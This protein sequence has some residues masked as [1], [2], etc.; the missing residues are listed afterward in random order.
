VGRFVHPALEAALCLTQ[1][2][3]GARGEEV[4]WIRQALDKLEGKRRASSAS[5]LYD[6]GLRR[7]VMDFQRERSLIHDGFVGT[8]T[9]VRLTLAIGNRK[10]H[11]S[12]VTPLA[13]EP[14]AM[15]YILDAL[16]KAERE[17]GIRRVPTLMTVHDGQEVQRNRLWAIAG[18]LV[19]APLQPPGSC[20]LC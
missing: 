8:E 14:A 1:L 6:E 3:L 19:F 10:P 15:S 2:S 20:C 5:D 13:G 16:K 7:R 17:R 4:V 12:H 9:L 18:G 11:R